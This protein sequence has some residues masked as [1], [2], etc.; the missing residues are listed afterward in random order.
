MQMGIQSLSRPP[1]Q[2]TGQAQSST[3]GQGPVNEMRLKEGFKIKLKPKL[4]LA[5]IL[6]ALISVIAVGGYYWLQKRPEPKEFTG[7]REKVTIG[8][9]IIASLIIIG[10][11][12]GFFSQEGLDVT[13][14]KYPTGKAA[15][16]G[17]FSGEV[18]MASVAETPIVFKSFEQ[19]DFSIIAELSSSNNFVRIVARKD[20]GIL[21]PADLR[22]KSIA[23]PQGTVFHFFS[24]L[25][26]IKNG[27]SENDVKLSFKKPEEL[28]SGLVRGEIDAFSFREPSI[29]EANKLLGDKAVVFAEPGLYFQTFNLAALKSFIKDK[30]ETIKRVLRA[31]IEAEEFT[32]K[33]P[34]K[35]KKIISKY[36]GI[37][38]TEMAAV[39]SDVTLQISLDQPLLLTLED[40]ARWAIKSGFTDKKEVPNYL[41]FIYLDGLEAVKPKAVTII[42]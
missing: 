17:M 37:S 6:T 23:T 13:T 30:P 29:S 21:K 26:L 9:D 25:F 1:Y 39:W 24:H 27:L 22:G 7:H 41:N 40:E 5:F 20:K 38:E 16:E 28:I 42:R 32:K 3:E 11:E 10:Q 35:A 4:V 31:L 34:D 12:Q 2:V 36:M 15:F 33:Y 8:L 19:Q 18:D 14:R